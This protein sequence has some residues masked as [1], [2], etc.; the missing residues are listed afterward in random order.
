[1]DSPLTLKHYPSTI[2][3]L[4]KGKYLKMTKGTETL[5]LE[6]GWSSVSKEYIKSM[7]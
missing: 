7:N 1:M 6:F 2:L 5:K 3:T 4:E